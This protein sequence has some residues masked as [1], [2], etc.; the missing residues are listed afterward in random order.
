M[1]NGRGISK[2]TYVKADEETRHRL[3]FELLDE[4]RELQ[5]R[6]VDI[7]EGRFTKLE[8]RKK[9]DTSLAAG[10]GGVAGFLTVIAQK[11]WWGGQ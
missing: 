10:T 7:C 8:T 6:Q 11:I 3:T 5:C 1:P 9:I 4:I 2:E